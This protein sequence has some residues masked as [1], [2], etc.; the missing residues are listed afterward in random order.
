MPRPVGGRNRALVDLAAYPG[1]SKGRHAA[2]AS[3]GGFQD[4]DGQRR[5]GCLA[6]AHAEIEERLF[7]D[8]LEQAPMPGL[9]R[10]MRHD[11]MIQHVAIDGE[12]NRGG[13]AADD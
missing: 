2:M 11:A 4:G 9:R 8:A 3:R 6:Q 10:Y 7:A 1:R 12:Q 5:T 13:S